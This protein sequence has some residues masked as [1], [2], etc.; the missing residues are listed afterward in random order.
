MLQIIG[1]RGARGL[2]AENTLRS[3]QKALEHHAD[4][5]ELDLRVTRDGAVVVNHNPAIHDPAGNRLGIGTHSLAELRTH[6]PDLL[7]FEELL[8][9]IPSDVHLLVEIK[10]REP[11]PPIIA[12]LEAQLTGQRA[13]ASLSIGSRDQ[14][15]LR[16]MHA[17]FPEVEM[18]VIER[19][20]AVRAQ[21]RAR[22]LDT[23]RL[24]MRSWWL[25]P[26]LLSAIHRAGYQL[27]PYT[28]NNPRKV[29]RWQKYLYGVVTD[30]P[31]LFDKP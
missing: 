8:A 14:S 16:R 21:W 13:A 27:S 6:K 5:L 19:W 15:I 18:V 22:Q 24:T 9:A 1:H 28:M 7:T 10:P 2:A 12:I 23:K 20:S 11:T 4:Q 31:D 30:R 3:F 25:W 26:G 17:A 29:R